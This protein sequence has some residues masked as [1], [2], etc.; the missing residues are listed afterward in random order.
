ME[1]VTDTHVYFWNGELSNKY[2]K[3]PF[4]YKGKRFQ[5]SE[6]AFMWEKAMQ[7]GDDHTANLIL[8]RSNPKVIYD[9]GKVVN[10][11][12]DK[13]WKSIKFEVQCMINY[14]KF[15][16]PANQSLQDLLLGTED[17][18][19]VYC[20]PYN[21]QWG[22]GLHWKDTTIEDESNWKGEN[23]L[24]KALMKVRDQIRKGYATGLVLNPR[25]EKEFGRFY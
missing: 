18:T 7:F 20:D 15:T 25:L 12:D 13:E 5:N 14:A 17:K 8:E 10:G 21:E 19:I 3:A 16:F 11:Y 1:K 24:G 4:D 6:Q 9:L 2:Q 23:L 22:I